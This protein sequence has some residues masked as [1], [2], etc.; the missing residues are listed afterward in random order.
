MLT[1]LLRRWE[2]IPRPASLIRRRT[3]FRLLGLAG[4]SLFGWRLIE[5]AAEALSA[6]ARRPSG[7]KHAASFSGNAF[8]VTSWLFDT[9]PPLDAASWRLQLAGNLTAP[10]S[11]S[12]A[13]LTALPA[14]EV[15][16]V[17][18]CTGGWWSEQLWRGIPVMD[19]LEARGLA[20]DA[21]EVAVISV[22]GHRWPFPLEDLRGALL[23]T[24]V[25]GEALAPDHGYP[26]RLVVPE[27][28]GFQ[29]VKWVGR[30]EVA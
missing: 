14:R 13:Q 8:P 1:H 18:D 5:G 10:G 15:R 20:A 7:S 23:A 6:G 19:V 3:A 12:F 16:A 9:T 22:T 21:R 28:R 29:W 11:I 4:V 26:I 25:G 2:G 30:I 17:L 27:R 24:H